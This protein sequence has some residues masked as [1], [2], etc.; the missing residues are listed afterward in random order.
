[1]IPDPR[2]LSLQEWADTVV[3]VLDSAWPLGR[4]DNATRW[5]DWAVG[6]VR[7]PNIAQRVLPDPY[8]FSDWR[9]WATRV[10]PILEGG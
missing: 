1:M 5:Q 10:V 8:Q 3:L 4:I 2:G 7:A 9:D 6:L